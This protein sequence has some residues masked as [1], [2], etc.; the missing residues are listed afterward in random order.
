MVIVK[1]EA[2]FG[3][4]LRSRIFSVGASVALQNGISEHLSKGK[5]R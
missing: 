1:S 2:L 5:E 4:G 3:T